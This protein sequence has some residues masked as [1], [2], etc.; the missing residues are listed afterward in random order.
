VG[1]E[2]LRQ[3][4]YQIRLSPSY[5]VT[6]GTVKVSLFGAASFIGARWSDLANSSRLPAYTKLD[7]GA[8]A[9]LDSGLFFS[10]GRITSTTAMA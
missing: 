9:K 2:V 6:V 4:K 10:V 7:L 3:P 5:D 8:Q 1:N